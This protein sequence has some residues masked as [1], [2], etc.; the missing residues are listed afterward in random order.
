MYSILILPEN[1]FPKDGDPSKPFDITATV[2]RSEA[3]NTVQIIAV[4]GVS[5]V[6]P[7]PT[8]PSQQSGDGRHG[9]AEA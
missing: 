7:T 8:A 2:V 4:N 6:P 1:Q 9:D 5:L 3:A